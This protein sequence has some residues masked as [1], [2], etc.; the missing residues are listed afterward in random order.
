MKRRVVHVILLF[1]GLAPG[2]WAVCVFA[3]DLRRAA[4][5]AA[6]TALGL[7]LNGAALGYPRFGV[8]NPLRVI[9][10]GVALVVLASVLQMWLWI[11]GEYL[12]GVPAVDV[13]QREM[14]L[15]MLRNYI[16]ITAAVMYVVVTVLVLRTPPG[17]SAPESGKARKR[18]SFHR[19]G[20]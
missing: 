11:R 5:L 15:L 9:A 19:Y 14:A 6:L 7:G 10:C 13:E 3:E 2:V 20:R 17:S 4:V 1:A 18:G 16:W 8:R 12:P